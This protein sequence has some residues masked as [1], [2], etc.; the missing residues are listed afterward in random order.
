MCYLLKEHLE[1]L[2]SYLLLVIK[3]YWKLTNKKKI[4]NK[5]ILKILQIWC[6]FL[7]SFQYH[8]IH[9]LRINRYWWISVI[10]GVPLWKRSLRFINQV[11]VISATFS[12]YY[13]KK[14]LKKMTMIN[15]F[16]HSV[17][18][19]LHPTPKPGKGTTLSRSV[20]R[21]LGLQVPWFICTVNKVGGRLYD[22]LSNSLGSEYLL[23]FGSFAHLLF[24][25]A[26]KLHFRLLNRHK[27]IIFS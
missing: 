4:K 25:I 10:F 14:K 24:T 3:K 17:S 13:K 12:N 8:F 6:F 1:S 26:A 20:L 11:H 16:L 27:K 9:S 18:Y 19:L 21:I 7:A 22:V 2:I 15:D 5:K 23:G